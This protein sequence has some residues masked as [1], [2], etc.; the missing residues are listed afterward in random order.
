MAD[1]LQKMAD[2]SRDRVSM[3]R[4]SWSDD[5]LDRPVLPLKRRGFDLIAEIKDRSPAEGELATAVTTRSARAAAYAEGGAAAISVL[6]EPFRFSGEIGHVEEVVEGRQLADD[7]ADQADGDGDLE[8]GEV[9]EAVAHFEIPVMRKDFLVDVSQVLEAKAAGASGVLLIAAILDDD[10]LSDM[11]IVAAEHGLFVLLES[12]GEE[13]LT[14]AAKLLD[15]ERHASRAESGELLFGINTRD[16][17][18]L[19]VDP[20]RLEQLAA[21]LPENVLAVAESGL[22][23]PGDAARVA[24]LG[25]SLALVGTALMKSDD[26]QRL[27]A[28]MLASGRS[29]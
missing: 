20:D 25:Y 13:D 1:F 9:V 19:A 29:A 8:A 14:R 17:R 24:G 3:L 5:Q 28:D 6:T 22:N 2:A 10:K 18:T 15:D 16:L 11:L 21:S 7:G 26:P 12:F 4:A 23:E 27:V